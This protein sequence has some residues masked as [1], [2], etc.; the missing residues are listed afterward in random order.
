MKDC[1]SNETSQVCFANTDACSVMLLTQ[2]VKFRSCMCS[3]IRHMC[4]DTEHLELISMQVLPDRTP[5]SGSIL[6]EDVA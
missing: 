3:S 2:L 1:C 6:I 4:D 5:L